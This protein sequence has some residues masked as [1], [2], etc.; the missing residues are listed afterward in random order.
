MLLPVS[1]NFTKLVPTAALSVFYLC[2]F[3]LLTFV[4]NKIPIVASGANNTT[5]SILPSAWGHHWHDIRNLKSIYK[6]FWNEPLNAFPYC[7]FKDICAYRLGHHS[8]NCRPVNVLDLI[9][10][11]KNKSL[12]YLQSYY[13]Y[14]PYEQKHGES[15]WTLYYQAVYLPQVFHIDKRTAHLSNLIVNGDITRQEALDILEQPTLNSEE[16]LELV[17]LVS[18][19]LKIPYDHALNP[20]KYVLPT[21]HLK[22]ASSS[23]L[24]DKYTQLYYSSNSDYQKEQIFSCLSL[25]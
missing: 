18:L 3:Y 10:Y 1:Q 4:A 7:T 22:F 25:S 13:S 17:N 20:A 14:R 9:H 24:I 21:S 15:A 11:E 19:K 6:F 23:R 12:Q 16:L 8:L 5:E 2:A